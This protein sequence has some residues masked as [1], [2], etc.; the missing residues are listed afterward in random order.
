MLTLYRCRTHTGEGGGDRDC[1]PGVAAFLRRNAVERA[2]GWRAGGGGLS[3]SALRVNIAVNDKGQGVSLTLFIRVF[4][5][6]CRDRLGR[7]TG[8]FRGRERVL[9]LELG[10]LLFASSGRGSFRADGGVLCCAGQ[11][12][13]ERASRGATDATDP[14]LPY[15]RLW[16]PAGALDR[17]V[18]KPGK[19]TSLELGELLLA[20]SSRGSFRAS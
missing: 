16:G 15:Q 8:A 13:W 19:G 1:T 2:V 18:S 3:C 20:S 12:W 5:K 14:S 6:N 10:E 17:G 9:P 4:D 7:S 11:H